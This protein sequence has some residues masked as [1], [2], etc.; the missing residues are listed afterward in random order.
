MQLPL[1]DNWKRLARKAWSIRLN[2]LCTVVCAA[3][4]AVQYIA[5]KDPSVGFT[6]FVGLL[7]LAAG[8]ARLV[9]QPKMHED[10]DA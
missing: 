1:V 2:L 3:D 9:P 10:K 7:S 6:V 5:P 4:V 8:V